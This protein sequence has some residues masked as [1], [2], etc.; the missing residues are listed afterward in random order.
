MLSVRLVFYPF[1]Y[2]IS[3]FCEF[4]IQVNWHGLSV[5]IYNIEFW[6]SFRVFQCRSLSL[7]VSSSQ[8]KDVFSHQKNFPRIFSNDQ[9]SFLK[10][11]VL[12]Y[13]QMGLG[14]CCCFCFVQKVSKIYSSMWMDNCTLTL[15]LRLLTHH[16]TLAF[17]IQEGLRNSEMSNED[18]I[19]RSTAHWAG[20]NLDGLLLLSMFNLRFQQKLIMGGYQL[21]D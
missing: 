5:G 18:T 12:P 2:A 1:P 15:S 6:R 4:N 3:K 21:Q 20:S 13:R 19:M 8:C 10:K 11:G 16:T 17:N 9:R 14:L 7:S